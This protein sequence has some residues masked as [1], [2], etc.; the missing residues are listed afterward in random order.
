MQCNEAQVILHRIDVYIGRARTDTYTSLL[1]IKYCIM[2]CAI[3]NHCTF[4]LPLL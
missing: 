1:R 3:S 2:C 4:T